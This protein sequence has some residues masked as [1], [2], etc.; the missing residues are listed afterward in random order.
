MDNQHIPLAEKIRPKCMEDMVGQL[1]LLGSTGILL[2]L[3][4]NGKLPSIVFWGAPGTGKTTLARILAS[5]TKHDF[6]EFSG[7]TG[8]SVELKKV[9]GKHREGKLFRSKPLVVFVDEIHRFN[10]VQQDILLAPLERGEVILLGATTENPVFHLNQALRSRCQILELAPL[11]P[12]EIQV[13][14]ERTWSQERPGEPPVPETTI[15]W[16]S[17]WAEGDLRS[18]ITGLEIL[19]TLKEKDIVSLREAL[20]KHMSFSKINDHYNLASAFQKS[21]RGSDPDASLYYLSRMILMGEDPHFIARRLMVCAAEDVGNADPQAFFLAEAASR[22]IGFIGWPEARI[23]LAQAVLYVANAPKSNAVITAIDA[24]MTAFD[25]PIP[26]TLLKGNHTSIQKVTSGDESY[27]NSHQDYAYHQNFLPI[28]LQTT[29]FYKPNR[30]QER[31]WNDRLEPNLT[32]IENLLSDWTTSNPNG[33]EIP[34]ENW[35]I[36]LKCSREAIARAVVKL[37]GRK[38]DIKRKL[39]AELAK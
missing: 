16:L 18:A 19:L 37:S 13:V 11:K 15:G 21:L 38:W 31:N 28:E 35:A 17:H 22:A 34:V 26:N 32:R 2:Q 5:A 23:P 33:G 1:H 6:F 3:I 7:S 36:Q 9:I 8:S 29:V 25:A 4:N 14:L 12:E 27:F 24:A 20:G 10:R 39:I 30:P